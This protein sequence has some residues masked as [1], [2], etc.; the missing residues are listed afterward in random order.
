MREREVPVRHRPLRDRI[1]WVDRDT[2]P[3]LTVGACVFALSAAVL[4][5]AGV[6]AADLHGP[7]HRWGIMDPAWGGTRS[8]YLLLHGELARSVEFNPAVPIVVAVVGAV[9]LRALVGLVR[10]RWFSFSASRRIVAVAVIVSLLALEVNQQ[11]HANLL[12][13]P[14]SG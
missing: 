12:T 14:W 1:R 7:L 11:M 10:G 3:W 6:P 13:G 4:A 5:V 9:V 8:V 2:A